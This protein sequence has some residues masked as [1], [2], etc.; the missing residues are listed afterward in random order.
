M[1]G[2]RLH[3]VQRG[4]AD[5]VVGCDAHQVDILHPAPAQPVGQRR[6][7][8]VGPFFVCWR[9]TMSYLSDLRK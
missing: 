2:S 6:A 9:Y 3:R 7:L 5:A 4:R 8:L 1:P